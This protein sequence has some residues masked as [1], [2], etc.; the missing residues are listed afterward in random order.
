M[1]KVFV[2]ILAFQIMLSLAACNRVPPV[3]PS[4][5]DSGMAFQPNDTD[6]QDDVR[7]GFSRQ[8]VRFLYPLADGGTSEVV[9]RLVLPDT[10]RISYENGTYEVIPFA[11]YATLYCE[12]DCVGGIGFLQYELPEGED[13]PREAIFNQIAM[14]AMQYWDI[15]QHF[16]TVSAEEAPYC[17]ALT[18]VVYASKIFPDGVERKNSAIVTYHPENQM[19]FALNLLDGIKDRVLLAE[20]DLRYIGESMEWESLSD[21]AMT[22]EEIAISVL[23]KG[24]DVVLPDTVTS[25]TFSIVDAAYPLDQPI[26]SIRF[27]RNM[28]L[29]HGYNIDTLENLYVHEQ[30]PNY[31]SVDGVIYSRDRTRLVAFPSGRSGSFSVPEG[32]VSIDSGA[33]LCTDLTSIYLPDSVNVL[34]PHALNESNTL[35]EISLPKSIR[36]LDSCLPCVWVETG[37]VNGIRQLLPNVTITYRGTYESWKKQTVDVYVPDSQLIC[38]DF[39]TGK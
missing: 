6:V 8:T 32:V 25:L 15:R 16:D 21:T 9:L 31:I 22:E 3:A 24:G 18:S 2:L 4:T 7:E 13:L 26:T 33:F 29:F 34:C 30:D 28:S 37:E 23:K 14:G 12:D 1:K 20:A 11:E 35:R 19:Y 39:E 17:T 27:G 36:G 38:T 10:W 5:D